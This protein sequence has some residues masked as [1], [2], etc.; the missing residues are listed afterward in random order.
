MSCSE[1]TSPT[2][3][4]YTQLFT[5]KTSKTWAIDHVIQ[6]KDGAD[7]QTFTLASCEKDDRYTFYANAER[8]Y[9]VSNGSLKCPADTPEPDM[10][11]SYN[12]SFSNANANLTMVIP[13]FFGN[14]VI[15]FIVTKATASEMIL[16]VFAD[17]K[18]TISYVFY[19]K[20]VSEN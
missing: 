20:S 4:T 6:R 5:G 14:Y 15:P 19:F 10:L 18:N 17:E 8:L 9:E 2:P 11:V 16:E 7:D 3:Y 13:H 12:W 1:E